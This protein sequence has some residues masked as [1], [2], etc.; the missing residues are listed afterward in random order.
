MRWPISLPCKKPLNLI[1][2]HRE[3]KTF[4]IWFLEGVYPNQRAGFT[5][6]GPPRITRVNRCLSLDN[7]NF[8]IEPLKSNSIL[9]DNSFCIR[10]SL[11]LGVADCAN[12]RGG[13]SR[14]HGLESAFC[15]FAQKVS[16]Q[17]LKWAF[18]F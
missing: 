4:S 1:N 7:V 2:G 18:F 17:N 13:H 10:P 5:D 3:I 11:I 15:E 14:R 16:P 8:V 9:T 6:K 12:H